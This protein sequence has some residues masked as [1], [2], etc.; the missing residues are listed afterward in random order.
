MPPTSGEST[1]GASASG[2][3]GPGSNLPWHLIPAF[4]PGETD[5][6]E[7]TRRLE[8]LGQVWPQD[9]LQHLAPR[10]CLLCEGTAFQKVVRLSPEKLKT[11]SLEGI[12]LV[13]ATL[14]G[15]WGR[16]KLELKYEKFEKA[17]FGTIQKVDEANESYV[18][19]HEVQFE[20]LINMGATLE[21]MRAYI[22]LRNSNLPSDDRKRI[23]VE[24]K[25]NLKYDDVTSSLQ[26]LGSRFFNE[27]QGSSKNVGKKTYDVLLADDDEEPEYPTELGE[28]VLQA[29]E[30]PEDQL[31]DWFSQEGDQDA[32][33]ISQFE[34]MVIETLQNDSETAAALNAYV[35]ARNRLL[36]KAKSRGFWSNNQQ[37]GKGKGKGKGSK[38]GH[39]SFQRRPSLA[40]RIA[41]STCRIC[42]QKGHWKWECPNKDKM[43]TGP[44]STNAAAFAGVA[45]SSS[46]EIDSLSTWNVLDDDDQPPTDAVAFV[47]QAGSCIKGITSGSNGGTLQLN[48]G[49]VSKTLHA[50]MFTALHR[51]LSHR[52]SDAMPY[53]SP[54]CP[55]K[56]H[57]VVQSSHHS[58]EHATA[59]F[60]SQGSHG[61]VDLGAS[62]SV[63]G[64]HQ[65]KELCANLPSETLRHMKETQCAV[66]FRFGNDS[67]VMGKRAVFIPIGNHWLKIIVVPSNTPFLIAN[68]VFRGLGACIDTEKNEIWF[69]KL[70]C[71]VPIQLS[72]RKLFTLDIADLIHRV[73]AKTSLETTPT[74]AVVCNCH[75]ERVDKGEGIDKPIM[76]VNHEAMNPIDKD[77]DMLEKES[78]NQRSSNTAVSETSQ[79]A[80][81][82]VAK[83]ESSLTAPCHVSQQEFR[84]QPIGRSLSS[85]DQHGQGEGTRAGHRRDQPHDLHRALQ[86]DNCLWSGKGGTT[87]HGGHRR[88]PL[89]DMV[90]GKLQ[91]Q[92]EAK[93]CEVHPL[94]PAL[95]RGARDEAQTQGQEHTST[96]EGSIP[97]ASAQ[98]GRGAADRS[99]QRD[100]H[101]IAG[102]LHVGADLPAT[103]ACCN[104]CRDERHAESSSPDG[105]TDAEGTSPP[106]SAFQCL[107]SRKESESREEAVKTLNPTQVS[108]IFQECHDH[109]SQ[110]HQ[111]QVFD[112]EGQFDK[113]EFIGLTRSDNWAAYEMWKYMESKGFLQNDHW[114]RKVK[115]DLMEIYCSDDSALTKAALHLGLKATRHGLR[116]GDLSTAEGR[117]RLYDRLLTFLPRDI[118]LSPK[119]KAWC[120]W[121]VFNMNRNPETAKRVM[122]AR[123]DDQVHLLLCDAVF[124]FQEWRQC[125]AHLEQPEGSQMLHQE[126]LSGVLNQTLCSKCDMC[127]AGQLTNPETG[128]RIRKRTQVLTTSQILF[129]TLRKLMCTRDH[130]HCEIAGS[131]R[132]V[133]GPRVNLSQFTE[134]YTKTFATRVIRAMIS[135]NQLPEKPIEALSYVTDHVD[136]TETPE[137]KRR[138]LIHKQPPTPAYQELER[139]QQMNQILQKALEIGPKVGKRSFTEGEFF[140]KVQEHFSDKRVVAIEICK[141]ADRYRAPPNGVTASNAP[142]RRTMGLHRNM[143]GHFVD[144]DWEDW[145][146]LSRKHLIRT[147]M[148]SKLMLTVFS[149]EFD[150]TGQPQQQSM[151]R[152]RMESD[153]QPEAK[154]FR[155]SHDQGTLSQ[156]TS[157]KPEDI[158]SEI[159]Q[160]SNEPVLSHHG[161]KFMRLSP[162]NR[163]L[164][165]KMHKNLGHPDAVTLGNV[166]RDQGWLSETIDSLS[167]MHCPT[168]FERQRPKIARPSHI[169]EPREFNDL[170]TIDA[171]EWTND[172]GDQ[173]LFYHILDSATNFHIAFIPPNRQSS[174]I[175]KGIKEQW[176]SW[177]GPPKC[178]MTD[179]AGEFCSEEF[180]EFVKQ[181]E[182]RTYVIPAEAHWQLGKCERHGAILQGM[183]DKYQADH[184]V[185]NSEEFLDALQH[186]VSA[187]NSLS[188]HRGFS[189]EILVLGKS[190]HDPYS[191]CN[192]DEATHE[193]TEQGDTS[194]F[195]QNLARRI[196]ARKAFIDADH[197]SKVRRAIQRRSRP[198]RDVFEVG[199]YVMFW[200]SGKGVKEGNW[201]GPGRVIARESSNVFWITHLTRLYRCAPEHIRSLSSREQEKCNPS[202]PQAPID[203][204]N[205]LGTGVFQFHDLIGQNHAETEQNTQTDP[206]NG[207]T[208][209]TVGET[210]N[211][212]PEGNGPNPH[213]GGGIE[214][215]S[216]IQ[217]DSEPSQV[218]HPQTPEGEIV[219]PI[220]VPV[221][222]ASF[223]DD[224]QDSPSHNLIAMTDNDHWVIDGK[225]ITRIHKEPRHRLFSP[226]NV[227]DC[228]V[229]I[230]YLK[231]ERTTHVQIADQPTWQIH[232]KWWQTTEAHQSLLT[233]W[234]GST[235]FEI[236]EKICNNLPTIQE[237]ANTC[238]AWPIKGTELEIALTIHEVAECSQK[239]YAKQVVYLASAAKRQKVEVKERDLKPEEL[240]LFQGAK[241][242]EVNSWLSTETVRRIARSQI[243]QD[244]ILRS[245]WVLTWKPIEESLNGDKHKPKARLVILGY[246]DPHLESLARDSPTMGRDTRTLIM[247]YAA[248]SHSRIKS[249]DIQT[250]F[251]RGSRQDG[252]ILGMEPPKEMRAAMDLK[253]WECCELLKSA[254][255]LVNA[256]LL[257]YVELK[258]AL[259]ALGMKMSPL[260]PCLF[261]LPK[262]DDQG[263]HGVLGIHVDD[264]LCTGDAVFQQAIDK[265]ESKYPFGSKMSND[266][267]FTGIHIHQR[268][269]HVIEL[270][271]TQYIEDIPFIDVDRPRRQNSELEVTEAERQALRGL[272]GSLQY[273]TT[274][275]R[276]DLAAKL[277]FVQSVITTAKVKD[278]LEANKILQEAK[279]TKQTKI[280]IKDIPLQDLRFVSF[281]DA[282]FATRAKATSQK[283]CLILAASKQIG[284]WQASDISPL[285]WYSR[286]IARVVGST[287]ASETYALSGSI[288]LLSWIR[289][290]WS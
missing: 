257:W 189:P 94:C 261:V 187:K 72:D 184:N 29:T 250:A 89:C 1:T 225:W 206:A 107:D 120:R 99:Q 241:M 227:Q 26:L 80:S 167:D 207:D 6:N 223:S 74:H 131:I 183:L 268:D 203:L 148:P 245:R 221:P 181:Y 21:E 275:T 176:M 228:P 4:R 202:E 55:S 287:L 233:V 106:E 143:V 31:V 101:G 123:I 244:Q 253:P 180:A 42:N 165:L 86:G 71:T 47:V 78:I 267:V 160:E 51:K 27:I 159:S 186:C 114:N 251:L 117:F 75:D 247:Q 73:R 224:S 66:N 124:Q 36:F 41:E 214:I 271:Q 269:D 128:E 166:L 109:M 279:N 63:I 163:S 116:D 288:D 40:Q 162:E 231:D 144:Q 20:D 174:E 8:F 34:D 122:K 67:T 24:A 191:N 64:D 25:G 195:Q 252:R 265:L 77:R 121:N 198:D 85:C 23:I 156:E 194:R 272:V 179:S 119:C 61:I 211:P 142:L 115:S 178:L 87:I 264:G 258:N 56:D 188:R 151:P 70:Q 83:C 132:L 133:N 161:P 236:D 192:E 95:C 170:I 147:G 246:E 46:Q 263:I 237:Y 158:P 65:L 3:P 10:A 226:S 2:T 289:L 212:S 201:N 274:N 48:N 11:S 54:L 58:K 91:D 213:Q 134:L 175:I 255:G 110:H 16:P 281:S 209:D 19:R 270:D 140:N 81:P 37:K 232:D 139:T 82:V 220:D 141:G 230:E 177:A 7:Y 138:K 286:K 259:I 126:E 204:P 137:A 146:K 217:P 208:Q 125:H 234:T 17:L 169:H 5:V 249:F 90:C 52:T 196:T 216:E 33:L 155:I 45:V 32:L 30:I 92:P 190:R 60:V 215:D 152:D 199:Q 28:T 290:Q 219:N 79:A 103:S 13:V 154:R 93:S 15:T 210:P 273:A 59:F 104:Q 222:E 239:D 105:R 12:K 240:K 285:V 173:F 145:T 193:W 280:V 39:T 88:P 172:K 254:Y 276:P 136:Q 256:P 243:P 69:R 200:R 248:S 130:S 168:C 76:G 157:R 62:L 182:I 9:Q 108:L 18:A 283:G 127:V 150:T 135:S 57:D 185:T 118:W 149:R 43:K 98:H 96:Q 235:R 97:F 153:L 278:L 49:E 100:G 205:H 14:G 68:S 164:I 112:K 260:D 22:L 53:A 266:F 229:P 242:K 284:E 38:S 129:D 197:D 111:E 44:P 171:V 262:K 102:R 113:G 218:S 50:S 282:S 35:E 84:D 238:A 277:S